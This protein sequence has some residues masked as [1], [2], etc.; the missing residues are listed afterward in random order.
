MTEELKTITVDDVMYPLTDFSES[1]QYTVG[2]Y[3]TIRKDLDL[4]TAEVKEAQTV[5]NSLTLTITQMVKNEL[6][7]KAQASVAVEAA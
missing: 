7:A 1:V 6:D 2:L 3:M 5:L 4:A